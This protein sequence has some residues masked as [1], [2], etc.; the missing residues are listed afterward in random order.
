MNMVWLEYGA[1]TAIIGG[2]IYLF[3]LFAFRDSFA[4]RGRVSW[5]IQLEMAIFMVLVGFLVWRTRNG[6][7]PSAYLG[8]AGWVWLVVVIVTVFVGFRRSS[9]A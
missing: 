6:S 1:Y 2:L 3:L 4:G 8:A 5:V 9:K 7:I